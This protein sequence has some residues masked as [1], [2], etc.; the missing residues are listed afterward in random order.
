MGVTFV[1]ELLTLVVLMGYTCPDVITRSGVW[2]G[3]PRR[4]LLR[5]N[6][7]LGTYPGASPFEV[8]ITLA[9]WPRFTPSPPVCHGTDTTYAYWAHIEWQALQTQNVKGSHH[10]NTKY[11]ILNGCCATWIGIDGHL[12]YKISQE[13]LFVH[14]I[15]VLRLVDQI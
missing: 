12:S 5:I 2:C 7:H 6:R 15:H 11:H 8:H 14:S 1:R 10:S 3:V 13:P 9:L 4:D